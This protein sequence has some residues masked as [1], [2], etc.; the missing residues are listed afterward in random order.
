[1]GRAA[2]GRVLGAEVGGVEVTKVTKLVEY[3]YT[4]VMTAECGCTV[5]G[6]EDLRLALCV[7]HRAGDVRR[8][9]LEAM[10]GA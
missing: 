6:S 1:M 4:P 2:I 10:T 8:R 9:V 3:V 5:W 7:R